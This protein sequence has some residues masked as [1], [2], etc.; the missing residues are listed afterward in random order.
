MLIL[1]TQYFG[2]TI[3]PVEVRAV[4]IVYLLPNSTRAH[5]RQEFGVPVS[6]HAHQ[7]LTVELSVI[8]ITQSLP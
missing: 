2:P 4:L 6:V 3:V 8:C 5:A 1:L 7:S